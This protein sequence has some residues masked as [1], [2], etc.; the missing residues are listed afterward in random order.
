MQQQEFEHIVPHLRQRILAEARS[1][2]LDNDSAEDV[3]QDVLLKL[4]ALRD[5]LDRLRSVE[6]WTVT[7][8][9]HLVL[10]RLRRPTTLTVDN[11]QPLADTAE[12]PDQRMETIDNEA[13]LER[14]LRDL[15]D[16]EYQVLHLRQVERR[17]TQEIATIVGI[18]E[19]SV[20]T[21]LSR[22]RRKLLESYK[23]RTKILT[24]YDH[25]L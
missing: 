6:A 7:V 23:Q 25:P 20:P 13:W 21:L 4:W 24:A 8:T 12:R 16:K 2:G 1:H 10:D 11:G 17:T 15:P 14:R 5:E 9:R 18:A 3:A 19:S 22:A